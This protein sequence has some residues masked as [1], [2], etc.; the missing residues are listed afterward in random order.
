MAARADGASGPGRETLAQKS[1]GTVYVTA[2][3]TS[4]YNRDQ[5]A[6]GQVRFERRGNVF[7][8]SPEGD[9]FAIDYPDRKELVVRQDAEEIRIIYLG[10]M[11]WLR[12]NLSGFVLRLPD[13]TLTVQKQGGKV[14]LEGRQGKSVVEESANGFRV[15]S[16]AGETTYA[17]N[18]NG[19]FEL[20]GP[21][22]SKHPYL[23]R[24]VHFE[25]EGAGVFIAFG[26]ERL[27]RAFTALSWEDPLMVR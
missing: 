26:L 8:F 10:K 4:R 1:W 17:R 20:S 15:T 23:R 9:G 19:V 14:T 3:I 27:G 21:R 11:C 25:Y 2:Q 16:P 6:L 24:G 5:D 18:E 22:L 13:D 7:A 12:R